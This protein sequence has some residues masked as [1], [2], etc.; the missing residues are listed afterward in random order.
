MKQLL[1][2][3][4]SR[5]GWL[6]Q[7]GSLSPYFDFQERSQSAGFGVDTVINQVREELDQ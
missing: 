6:A 5:W 1:A 4:A 2:D 3:T 7:M